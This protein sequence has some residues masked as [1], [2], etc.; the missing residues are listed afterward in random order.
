V[1][2]QFRGARIELHIARGAVSEPQLQVDGVLQSQLLLSPIVA[3]QH[4]KLELV[5]PQS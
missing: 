2:R 4:Y 1:V 3:G 5:L